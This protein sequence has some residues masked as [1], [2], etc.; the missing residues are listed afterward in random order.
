MTTQSQ[1]R[2]IQRLYTVRQRQQR[3]QQW[4]RGVFVAA[5]ITTLGWGAYSFTSDVM[6]LGDASPVLI[7]SRTLEQEY[8]ELPPAVARSI[9]SV[10]A[11]QRQTSQAKGVVGSGV[12]LNDHQVLTAGHMADDETDVLSCK[13]TSVQAPGMLTAAAASNLSA[14]TGSAIHGGGTDLALLS[15][16]TDDNF[17]NLPSARLASSMPKAGDTV[18]FIN[19]QPSADGKLRSPLTSDANDPVILSGIVLGSSD[20]S[21]GLTSRMPVPAKSLVFRVAKVASTIRQ[22]AA[23]FASASSIGNPALNRP[24]TTCG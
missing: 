3:W 17:R 1:Q 24:T 21:H 18:F 20:Y 2:R 8:P 10:V 5:V 23:I 6:A 15:V 12:I 13:K 11:L 7:G 22:I 9:N 16:K 4:R 19:Y 14:M